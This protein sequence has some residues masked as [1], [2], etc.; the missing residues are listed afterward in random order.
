MTK[1]KDGPAAG[2]TLMLHR[3]PTFLRV[4]FDGSKWDALDQID[5]TPRAGETCFAYYITANHGW[6]HIKMAR[7]GSGFYWRADYTF[8]A[9]QPPQALM[10][11]T[12][13]WQAWCTEKAAVIPHARRTAMPKP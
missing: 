7:S 6:V 1:F 10:R 5:D 4:V 9:E 3:S 2:Q 12:A 8:C 13:A 11:D